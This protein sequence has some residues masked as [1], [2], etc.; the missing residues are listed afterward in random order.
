MEIIFSIVVGGLAILGI[1]LI[2]VM[3]ISG[4]RTVLNGSRRR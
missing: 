3:L 2:V 4:I 1:G